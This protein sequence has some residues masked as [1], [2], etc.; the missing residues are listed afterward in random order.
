MKT[1]CVLISLILI[2]RN[3]IILENNSVLCFIFISL[4]ITCIF[5]LAIKQTMFVSGQ[6]LL[7]PDVSLIFKLLVMHLSY[8]TWLG[9]VMCLENTQR[10]QAFLFE[11]YLHVSRVC[12]NV[13]YRDTN[14]THFVSHVIIFHYLTVFVLYELV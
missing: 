2:L 10:F 3:S 9:K 14:L 7:L 1:T 8:L 4:G 11:D 5:I 12:D 6:L 13:T